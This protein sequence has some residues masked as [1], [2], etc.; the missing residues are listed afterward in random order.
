MFGLVYFFLFVLRF[1][2]CV[3]VCEMFK[4]R[5]VKERGQGE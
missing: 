5:E 1:A 2:V 4:G 3:C